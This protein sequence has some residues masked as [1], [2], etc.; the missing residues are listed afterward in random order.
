[1]NEIDEDT[2]KLKEKIINIFNEINN[3]KHFIDLL[4]LSL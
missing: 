4:L 2:K 1:M 3:E